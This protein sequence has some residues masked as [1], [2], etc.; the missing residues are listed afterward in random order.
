VK[1][2]FDTT[3]LVAASEKSHPH[4]I[5]AWPA[6]RRVAAGQDNGFMSVHSIAELY[7]SLTRLPVQP[8]I[9]PVEAA[10]IVTDNVLP[11]FEAVLVGKKDYLEALTMVA[12]GGWSG[13]KI[14]DALLLGC[15]ARC[16]AERI[17]TF[18]LADFRQ[19]APASL[20]G[21]ICAPA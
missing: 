14:Y 4:Y 21:K 10:R 12:S 17:Y 3:I 7:A 18:N 8:R 20:Q 13:A 6:L 15:A 5:R 1:I 16:A 11:H 9:H 19:L 2:F